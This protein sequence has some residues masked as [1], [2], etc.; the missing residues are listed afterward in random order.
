MTPLAK[1]FTSGSLALARQLGG[2]VPDVD[3]SGLTGGEGLQL[4][5]EAVGQMFPHPH[6]D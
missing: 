5:H 4:V 6:H 2:T 3:M 1:A